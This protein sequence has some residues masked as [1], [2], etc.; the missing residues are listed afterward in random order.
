MAFGLGAVVLVGL[1]AVLFAWS[2][3]AFR[4][5]SDVSLSLNSR[6]LFAFLLSSKDLIWILIEVS[7]LDFT[8]K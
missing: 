2:F 7:D 4:V 5:V 8:Q 3:F 6:H 1:S